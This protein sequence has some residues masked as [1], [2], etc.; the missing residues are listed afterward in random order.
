MDPVTDAM[1]NACHSYEGNKLDCQF[2][3]LLLYFP[4]GHHLSSEEIYEQS[5]DNEEPKLEIVPVVI[6]TP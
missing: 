3:Y 5:G 6:L 4:T 1:D 2:K